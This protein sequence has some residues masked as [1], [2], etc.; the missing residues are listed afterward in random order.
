MPLISDWPF[1]MD[2]VSKAATPKFE[3]LFADL[4]RKGMAVVFCLL[5]DKGKTIGCLGV[6]E[7][8]H[9]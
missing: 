2:S 8:A 7:G 4:S 3:T 6:T 1:Y 5:V 9:I